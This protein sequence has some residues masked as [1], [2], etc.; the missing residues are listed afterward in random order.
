M[1]N[2]NFT[3]SGVF[4]PGLTSNSNVGPCIPTGPFSLS[5]LCSND[6]FFTVKL[7]V[8]GKET[9]H[10]FSGN[11]RCS[12]DAGDVVL[13]KAGKVAILERLRTGVRL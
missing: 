1:N 2:N 10:D 12:Q 11:V 9:S 6:S 5:G 4:D 3:L 8:N 7:G 13:G